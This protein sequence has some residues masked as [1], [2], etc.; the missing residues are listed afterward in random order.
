M[1]NLLDGFFFILKVQQ[2]A[3]QRL[4]FKWRQKVSYIV[5]LYKNTQIMGSFKWANML[6]HR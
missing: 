2:Q 1:P 5:R 3:K 6:L 4:E